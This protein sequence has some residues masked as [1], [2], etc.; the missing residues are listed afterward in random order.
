M[1]QFPNIEAHNFHYNLPDEQI[2]RF[3][4]NKRDESNLLV[5]QAGNISHSK[6]KEID[7]ILDKDFTLFFNNTRVIP[8]RLHFRKE[9]GGEIEI[10]LL[11]PVQ[12]SN[13][14]SQA[15]LQT[16]GC[17]WKCIIGGLKKWKDGMI[18]SRRTRNNDNFLL[19]KAK[20]IDRKE[21][22]VEFWW[23]PSL[24]PFAEIISVFGNTPLPPYLKREAVEKDKQQYQTVYAKNEGAVA[25][26]TAGL[27]FTPEVLERLRKKGVVE[28]FLTLH[29]GGGTFQ[30][31][32]TAN[33]LEHTM[34]TEQIIVSQTNIR[35]LMAANKVCAVGTTSMRTLESLYWLA[36]EVWKGNENLKESI[37]SGTFLIEKLQPY[38]H[39]F[40]KL[41]TKKEVM[42]AL[43]DFML[44]NEVGNL[45]GETQIMIVPS[46]SFRCCDALITNFHQ[47]ETT[48]MLL[49]AAFIGNDWRKVYGEALAKNYRFLSFGDSSLLFKNDLY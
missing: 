21:Q 2:A 32:R 35:N 18:L 43:L 48:L 24:L 15:M 22:L 28:D 10:F 7:Q 13:M 5:Y 19:L 40:D 34:H 4:L 20:L 30:P 49:V 45:T 44:A 33:V 25:A 6:F 8:A 31:I 27:H 17:V 47:P 14:V 12:P 39:D 38:E 42:Q 16:Q 23:T 37:K 36:L 26:P 11:N 9:S 41:P 29:V 46:Y 3:P 1:H